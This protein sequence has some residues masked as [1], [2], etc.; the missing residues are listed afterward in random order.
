MKLQSYIIFFYSGICLRKKPKVWIH[1]EIWWTFPKTTEFL[2]LRYTAKV[3]EKQYIGSRDVFSRRRTYPPSEEVSPPP[4]TLT[5]VLRK[6]ATPKWASGH[7]MIDHKSCMVYP[8]IFGACGGL[9][10]TEKFFGACGG[11]SL[12]SMLI[13]QIW[14][15]YM[16]SIHIT[17]A[18]KM[19]VYK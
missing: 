13:M 2:L 7:S 1:L 11:L 14:H 6:S 12:W 9:Y 4:R 16:L 17:S 3:R 19:H 5:L 8:K 10:T 18:S 15:Y